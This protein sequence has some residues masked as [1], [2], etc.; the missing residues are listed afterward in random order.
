MKM[1]MPQ[2][3]GGDFE[4]TPAGTHV[5]R[6]YRVVDLGTQQVEW[7]GQ[8]KHQRKVM[9]SWELPGE[10]MEDGRPFSAHQRYTFSSSEKSHFRKHL[11]SWR[12]LAFKDEDFGEGGFDI[13]NL[14][15]VPCMLSIVHTTKSDKTYANVAG[16]MKL[17]KGMDA[18][19]LANETLFLSLAP[20][21]FDEAAFEKLSDNIKDTVRKSPEYQEIAN[22]DIPAATS[23][24][25]YGADLDDEIPF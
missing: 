25:D 13:R 1:Y 21:E 6:C 23:P 24:D 17:P 20:G 9:L 4:T 19:Q 12:G 5:A 7:Q 15:G 3:S 2:N 16:V 18:P 14:L 8:M 10:L 22:G 11:E